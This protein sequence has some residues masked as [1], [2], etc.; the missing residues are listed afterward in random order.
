MPVIKKDIMND[1]TE[2]LLLDQEIKAKTKKL[3]ELRD[4]IEPYMKDKELKTIVTSVGHIEIKP[5]P[6]AITTA[7][8]SSYEPDDLLKAIDPNLVAECIVERVDK[9]IVDF[10]IVTK[11]I[12]KEVEELKLM[13]LSPCFT[14]KMI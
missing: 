10:L 7:R 5:Q 6:R 11:K 4:R 9:E 1:V 2:Y 14:V 3:K 8:Y 13:P 12:P